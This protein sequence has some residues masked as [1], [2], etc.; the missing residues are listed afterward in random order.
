[1][2]AMHA[3]N[4]DLAEV[5]A[6]RG[7]GATPCSPGGGLPKG[8]GRRCR[9]VRLHQV[10]DGWMPP[11]AL[12][13]AAAQAVHGVAIPAGTKEEPLPRVLALL[14]DV[15]LEAQHSTDFRW[16][17]LQEATLRYA[18]QCCAMLCACVCARTHAQRARTSLAGACPTV[19]AGACLHPGLFTPAARRDRT[20]RLVKLAM[21][22]GRVLLMPEPVCNA[23]SWSVP[24][25]D[26]SLG[27][28][29]PV[30]DPA[31]NRTHVKRKSDPD[32]VRLRR[33]PPGPRLPSGG[34]LGGPPCR[35]DGRQ[36]GRHL[37]AASGGCTPACGGS[38]EHNSN[39]SLGR[40]EHPLLAH[41]S[42]HPLAL[43]SNSS[44]AWTWTCIATG[45]RT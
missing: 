24:T 14:P 1:M 43:S 5:C 37:D 12:R 35:W 26:R 18:V 36:A 45:G 19:L 22:L 10:T 44:T 38:R 30:V 4:Y 39:W 8:G 27:A 6:P 2:K 21:H 31:T 7:C 9:C 32:R 20:A 13:R 28:F 3:F 40:A 15:H 25:P 16:G 29:E 23:S 34:V 11:P 33:C 42:P 41:P 17:P